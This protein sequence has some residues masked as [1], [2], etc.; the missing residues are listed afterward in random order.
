MSDNG[1]P[2]MTE[3]IRVTITYNPVTK[4]L[5][6]EANTG[7]HILILGMMHLAAD[8]LAAQRAPAHAGR[9]LPVAGVLR[10]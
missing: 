4:G 1:N 5:Q 9:I 6:L 7:D 10:Q 3:L 2:T 8:S